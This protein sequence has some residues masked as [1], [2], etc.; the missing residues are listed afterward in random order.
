M[1][2]DNPGVSASDGKAA[3]EEAADSAGDTASAGGSGSLHSQG[4]TAS[5]AGEQV[6]GPE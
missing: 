3:G 4:D 5:E 6:D 2:E 1:S